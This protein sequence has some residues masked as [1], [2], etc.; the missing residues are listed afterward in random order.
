MK[1]RVSAESYYGEKRVGTY[2]TEMP[3]E[4][5]QM[6]FNFLQH[7]GMVAAKN[8]GEDTSGRSKI[9]VLPVDETVA[10]AFDMAELAYSEAR[11]RGHMIEVPDLNEINEKFD[12][13]TR[14]REAESEA[15]EDAISAKRLA[16]SK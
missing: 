6:A 4:E 7:W 8:T 10:R 2:V 1:V 3:N 11:R 12:A 15:E 5:A 9:D 14:K 16:K 13:K